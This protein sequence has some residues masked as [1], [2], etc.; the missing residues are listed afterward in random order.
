MSSRVLFVTG[1]L[2]EPSLR[3]VLADLAPAA[4]IEPEVAVL[5]ITVAALLTTEWIA[6]QLQ[7]PNATNRVILP[8]FCR[9]D[10]S[11]IQSSDG[12]PVERGP[13]DL[14]DL[15]EYL[16]R[17]SWPAG[18]VRPIRHRDHRRD[19]PRAES[20]DRANSRRCSP[21][22]NQRRRRHRP[23]LRP[24][25]HWT[26]TGEVTRALRDEG[27]RVSVDSFNSVEVEAAVAAGAELVLSVN[28]VQSPPGTRLAER[29]GVE[30]VAI[31]DTPAD[32]DSLDATINEL[33]RRRRAI[34]HRPD[35]RADRLRL[36]GVAGPVTSKFAAAIPM[37]R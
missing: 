33:D 29:F 2:A 9:G 1:K 22:P 10:L 14:R 23:R 28:G 13:K 27:L 7:I 31:P 20:L 5:P 11:A 4:G 21:F 17:A 18:V 37:P 32:L 35:P 6:R 24:G 26:G 15:P 8:G 30:V 3:R 16:R 36:R 19:Q 34:P 12:V 25:R